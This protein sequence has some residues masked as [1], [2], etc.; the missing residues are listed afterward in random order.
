[1]CCF[2]MCFVRGV[3][4][5]VA[6]C[7]FGVWCDVGRFVFLFFLCVGASLICSCD[8]CMVYCVRSSG[9]LFVLFCSN[10]CGL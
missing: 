8:V 7:A 3:R 9:S 6:C 10:A 4:A 2:T 1:M 5:C